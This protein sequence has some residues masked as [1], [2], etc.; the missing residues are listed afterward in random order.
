[1]RSGTHLAIDLILNNFPDYRRSP[2]YIDA[3]R[4]VREGHD[5]SVLLQCGTR[6]IKT[7]YPQGTDSGLLG[8]V[9]SELCPQAII[10]RPE[11]DLEA[12]F[13]SSKRFG[14]PYSKSELADLHGKTQEYWN[15]WGHF[16]VTF[17][18]LANPS[19]ADE[20]LRRFTDYSGFAMP[21]RIV[22]TMDSKRPSRIMLAKMFT[23]ILGNRAPTINTSIQLGSWGRSF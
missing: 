22:R 5:P 17:E 7:H 18:E 21:K 19:N 1:M 13:E 8:D 4:Y 16:S 11:R 14:L 2:L 10:L 23:R 3:D 9:L 12:I 20:I 6:L 15:Q